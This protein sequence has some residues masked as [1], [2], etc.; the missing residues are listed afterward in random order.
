MRWKQIRTK[1]GGEGVAIVVAISS[2]AI[3]A[4]A[5]QLSYALGKVG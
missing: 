5:M 1:M 4:L 2:L 3:S